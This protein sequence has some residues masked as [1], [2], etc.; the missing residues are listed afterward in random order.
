MIL[1]KNIHLYPQGSIV[2][3]K[4][5]ESETWKHG[6]LTEHR[7]KDHNSTSYKA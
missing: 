1:S 4:R 7:D 5:E 6:L 3:V 2:A